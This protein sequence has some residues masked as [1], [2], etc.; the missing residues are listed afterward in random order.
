MSVHVTTYG[1]K[2]GTTEWHIH[3]WFDNGHEVYARHEELE[4]TSSLEEAQAAAAARIRQLQER[5][6][7]DGRPG[8]W[9]GDLQRGTWSRTEHDDDGV[10]IVDATWDTSHH[11]QWTSHPGDDGPIEWEQLR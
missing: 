10:T 7:L 1:A 3:L 4:P 9:W 11:P 5:I 6:V 2:A 8:T